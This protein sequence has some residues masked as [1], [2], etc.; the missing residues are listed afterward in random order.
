METQARPPRLQEDGSP[1]C[2]RARRA[3]AAEGKRLPLRQGRGRC[4]LDIPARSA[5]VLLSASSPSSLPWPLLA[6]HLP[7]L[8]R[9]P[10][11]SGSLPTVGSRVGLL[12][13]GDTTH[14]SRVTEPCA[15]SASCQ[16]LSC[17]YSSGT[18]SLCVSKHLG[19]M[20]QEL[21][22]PFC[23]SYCSKSCR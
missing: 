4:H 1:A 7:G 22:I 16:N 6:D 12:L 23:C 21:L 11:L 19:V 15:T 8:L 14:T 3:E 5:Q 20:E 13:S 10:L 17:K 18:C 2:S 9:L